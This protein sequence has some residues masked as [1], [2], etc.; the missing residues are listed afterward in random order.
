MQIERER[1]ASVVAPDGRELTRDDLPPP[2]VQRWVVRRKAEV[3]AAVEGGMLSEQDACERYQ[4]S[5]E[6]FAGWKRLL[7]RH[8][9][10]GLR[11]TRLQSYR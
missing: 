10:K 7:S 8:G 6:E 4:L 5:Q 1:I 2:G 9:V 11:A 3:V